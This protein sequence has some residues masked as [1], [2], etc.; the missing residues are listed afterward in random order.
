MWGFCFAFHPSLPSASSS[1][2]HICVFHL[3]LAGACVGPLTISMQSV[4]CSPL[5]L[6]WNQVWSWTLHSCPS[7]HTGTKFIFYLLNTFQDTVTLKDCSPSQ[8]P[9]HALLTLSTS[10]S[11]S[12]LPSTHLPYKAQVSFLLKVFRGSY[13]LPEKKSEPLS[14]ALGPFLNGALVPSHHSCCPHKPFPLVLPHRSPRVAFPFQ[15]LHML[16]P[17]APSPLLP[18]GPS[19]ATGTKLVLR[20]CTETNLCVPPPPHAGFLT[21]EG[22]F[23]GPRSPLSCEESLSPP[24][25][26]TRQTLLLLLYNYLCTALSP[27]I[28]T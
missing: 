26:M 19:T 16:F 25:Q 21:P 4:T 7:A 1:I 5:S 11:P 23:P 20:K 27:S 9:N 2:S 22:W 10:S 6:S 12:G 3:G 28:T 13:F 18:R 14:L 17:V 8:C 15:A 24:L